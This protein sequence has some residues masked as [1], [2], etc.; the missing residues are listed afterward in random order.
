ME[1][2][3]LGLRLNLRH[4]NYLKISWSAASD[5]VKVIH[6]PFDCLLLLR[7]LHLLPTYGGVSV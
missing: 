6:F 5:K 7:N 3:I 4:F 2:V 1:V